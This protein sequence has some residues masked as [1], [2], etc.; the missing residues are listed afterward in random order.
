MHKCA[1]EPPTNYVPSSSCEKAKKKSGQ[2]AQTFLAM[3]CNEMWSINT[4]HRALH[5]S[6]PYFKVGEGG[7][8]AAG[9][10][11]GER[12]GG[13]ANEA[14]GKGGE[15]SVGKEEKGA[16]GEGGGRGGRWRRAA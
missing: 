5:F 1:M 14:S 10:E 16:G 6:K 11:G 7:A 13:V 2:N 15:R 8:S 12:G 9:G 3:G 4:S